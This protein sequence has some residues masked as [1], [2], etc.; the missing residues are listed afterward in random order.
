[1]MCYD[2]DPHSWV[3]KGETHERLHVGCAKAEHQLYII[4]TVGPELDP[5]FKKRKT[6]Q[7]LVKINEGFHLDTN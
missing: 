4:Y 5:R 7:R 6:K 2:I 1:M 3:I